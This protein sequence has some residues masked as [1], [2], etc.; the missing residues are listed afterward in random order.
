MGPGSSANAELGPVDVP[1]TWGGDLSSRPGL[2][3]NWA[4]VRDELG[5]KGVVLE[6]DMFLLPQGVVAGGIQF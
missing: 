3:G 5:K 4:G 2:S 6:A 1:P